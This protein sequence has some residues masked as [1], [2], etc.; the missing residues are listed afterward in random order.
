MF[1]IASLKPGIKILVDNIPFEV[2]EA[3]HS[4][5]ARSVGQ[6]QTKFKNLLNNSVISKVF[7]GNITLEPADIFYKK[8]QFLYCDSDNFIFMDPKTFE[9]IEIANEKILDKKKWLR[10]EQEVDLMFWEN[11]AIGINLPAKITLKVKEALPGVKGDR[12]SAGTKKITL[13]TGAQI[14]A[15]L[16]IKT[17]DKVL[18]NTELNQYIKRI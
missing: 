13:E 4:K 7:S 5:M 1:S 14:D 11:Q 15:P 8:S 12:Q 18:I 9:Q 10:E 2:L 17:G 6:T 3:H 16:F